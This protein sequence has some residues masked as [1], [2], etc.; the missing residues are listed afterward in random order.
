MKYIH[1]YIKYI[2][3]IYIY[4]E[5]IPGRCDESWAHG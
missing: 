3:N 4:T 1:T 5:N 2:Q